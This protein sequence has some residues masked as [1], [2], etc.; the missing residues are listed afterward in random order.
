MAVFNRIRRSLIFLQ[1]FPGGFEQHCNCHGGEEGLICLHGSIDGIF[2]LET[3][4]HIWV[5]CYTVPLNLLY[6][7]SKGR[8]DVPVSGISSP[9]LVLELSLHLPLWLQP[10]TRTIFFPSVFHVGINEVADLIL[11]DDVKHCRQSFA[12]F[13]QVMCPCSHVYTLIRPSKH[14]SLLISC[15]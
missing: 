13:L 2:K 4:S 1:I 6:C 3:P 9:L 7:L 5:T 12:E 10:L 8:T 15:H 11:R 14:W